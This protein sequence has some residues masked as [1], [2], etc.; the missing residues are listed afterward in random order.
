MAC[1]NRAITNITTFVAS[2]SYVAELQ[3]GWSAKW[4][5]NCTTQS[6]LAYQMA[7]ETQISGELISKGV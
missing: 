5:F 4:E 2:N 7:Q 3:A 1:T 6:G